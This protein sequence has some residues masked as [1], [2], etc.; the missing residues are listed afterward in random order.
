MCNLILA[1]LSWG[2]LVSYGE[3]EWQGNSP[4][5]RNSLLKLTC[6]KTENDLSIRCFKLLNEISCIPQAK[7]TLVKKDI[8]VFALS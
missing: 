1:K 8:N 2:S 5:A 4:S 3:G 7:I 6:H